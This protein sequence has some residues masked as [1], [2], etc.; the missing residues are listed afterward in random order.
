MDEK[1]WGIAIGDD[2]A[3]RENHFVIY[4]KRRGF[5]VES[6]AGTHTTLKPLTEAKVAAE[7]ALFHRAKVTRFERW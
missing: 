3:S 4:S 2:P 6:H 1:V 7:I 5:A